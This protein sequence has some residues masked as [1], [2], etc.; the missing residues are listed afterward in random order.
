MVYS[1][2]NQVI[3]AWAKRKVNSVVEHQVSKSPPQFESQNPM[4]IIPF[5]APK[6]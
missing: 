1:L 5:P 2:L 3:V 4:M 6:Y